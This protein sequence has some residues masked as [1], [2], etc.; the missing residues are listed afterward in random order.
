MAASS[1][2]DQASDIQSIHDTAF[3]CGQ[4]KRLQRFPL[5][6]CQVVV[7]FRVHGCLD[8]L[9]AGV[10]YKASVNGMRPQ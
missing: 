1:K 10:S 2:R 6:P 4:A 9:L 8:A 3:G 5:I 7:E